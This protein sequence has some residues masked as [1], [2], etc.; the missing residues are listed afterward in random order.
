MINKLPLLIVCY[1]LCAETQAQYMKESV[2]PLVAN[3]STPSKLIGRLSFGP[4]LG[5]QQSSASK[6]GDVTFV[7]APYQLPKPRSGG[8]AGVA[9]NV[10]YR[11]LA[12]QPAVMFSQKGYRTQHT[13][14]HAYDATTN[15]ALRHEVT[16]RLNYLEV[17]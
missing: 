1:L 5:I 13:Y 9:F 4:R 16:L 17:P 7:Y 15:Y 12:I 10:Q 11:H 3:A 8:Q 2:K 14:Q 6:D